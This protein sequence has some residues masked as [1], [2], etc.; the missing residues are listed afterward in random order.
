MIRK[1]IKTG[2]LVFI[3]MTVLTGVIYPAVVTVLAQIVFPKQAAGS[4][5]YTPDGTPVGSVLI[6]QPFT[7]QGYFWSRPSA[8][9]GF[10]DNPMASGGSNLG[11]TN[12]ELLDRIQSRARALTA[13][14]ITTTVPSDL[15]EG[16]GSGLDPDIS[17]ASTLVQI[18]RIAQ[19]RH[20][21]DAKV[22]VLVKKNT[23]GGSYIPLTVPRVNVLQL[24]LALDKL[25]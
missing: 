23:A 8:T 12:Q 6:G 17:L 10:P 7:G 13:T 21:S 1:E 5:I 18:P 9:A 19:A 20:I 15:V 24:N 14:G 16:S 25:R 4:I 3:V 2:I 22:Y 11:P